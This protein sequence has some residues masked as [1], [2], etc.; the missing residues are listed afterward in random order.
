MILI[1]FLKWIVF[2]GVK[3][4]V[5]RCFRDYVYWWV[6]REGVGGE[7]EGGRERGRGG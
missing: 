4:Y 5:L 2:N 6:G 3:M 7:R 1:L